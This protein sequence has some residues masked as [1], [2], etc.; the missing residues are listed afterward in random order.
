MVVDET[1]ALE[2]LT[3][4]VSLRSRYGAAVFALLLRNAPARSLAG[5]PEAQG[6]LLQHPQNGG[7]TPV[8]VKNCPVLHS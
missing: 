5:H 3:L 1:E 7:V 8:H 6:L 4:T 2:E